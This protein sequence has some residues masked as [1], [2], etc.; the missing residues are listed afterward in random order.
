MHA[1]SSI[2]RVLYLRASLAV[3][4]PTELFGLLFLLLLLLDLRFDLRP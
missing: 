1:E 2:G 4:N 3:D